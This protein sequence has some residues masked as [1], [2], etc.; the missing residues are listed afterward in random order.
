MRTPARCTHWLQ[1]PSVSFDGQAPIP[2][3]G[4]E[5]NWPLVIA[6]LLIVL[7]QLY[8]LFLHHKPDRVDYLKALATLPIDVSFLVVSLF[9]KA[10]LDPAS[11]DQALIGL[12]VLY[13]LVS[14][15]ATILWRVCDSAIASKLDGNFLWA[16][17][18]NAALA[19]STF[20]VAIQ[21]VR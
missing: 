10:A 20:Y 4:M 9:I 1:G 7:K 8:K 14:L 11:S 2:N 18:L 3:E 15:V 5:V 16:F 13:L 6:F 17:P 12:M 21:F 19:G